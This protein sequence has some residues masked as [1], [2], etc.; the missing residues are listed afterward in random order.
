M[1]EKFLQNNG[2]F[3]KFLLVCLLSHLVVGFLIIYASLGYL[4]IKYINI[5]EGDQIFGPFEFTYIFLESLI[6]NKNFKKMIKDQHIYLGGKW[7]FFFL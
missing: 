7:I 1:L 3:L 2:L 4:Y 6:L 5:K